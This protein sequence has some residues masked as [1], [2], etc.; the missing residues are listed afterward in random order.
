PSSLDA[1]AY[2]YLALHLYAEL[3]DSELSTI[4]NTD[5]PRLA[6]FCERM[7]DLLS[8]RPISHLPSTDLPSFFSGLFTSPRTWFSRNIWRSNIEEVKR[9]K[10]EAQIK[11]ERTRNLSIFGAI[12]FVTAYIT[13]NGIISI[14]FGDEDEKEYTGSKGEEIDEEVDYEEVDYED[15]ES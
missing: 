8:S 6:R 15:N 11:F 9:E 12:C 3:P 13:W 4:L 10:S 2:S 1:I 14:E 5:Y 7:K